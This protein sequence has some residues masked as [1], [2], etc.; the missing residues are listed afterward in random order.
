MKYVDNGIDQK[1]ER[2]SLVTKFF[3]VKQP[4]EPYT[5]V[6]KDM[7]IED[8]TEIDGEEDIKFPLRFQFT[9]KVSLFIDAPSGKLTI[10]FD[11]SEIDFLRKHTSLAKVNNLKIHIADPGTIINYE[12]EYVFLDR[13]LE[14][15][16]NQK[17]I[18]THQWTN[19]LLIESY[20]FDKLLGRTLVQLSDL[21]FVN[22]REPVQKMIVINGVRVTLNLLYQPFKLGQVKEGEEEE[23]EEEEGSVV[24]E[25]SGDQSKKAAANERSKIQFLKNKIKQME[26]DNLVARTKINKTNVIIY[27][28]FN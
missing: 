7:N 19:K 23:E 18:Q 15:E 12:P 1:V 9:Y 25:K 27:N 2:E 14:D 16:S 11:Q 10:K 20:D 13:S 3:S 8:P 5:C 4:K 22:K 6:K 26:N 28:I 21:P 24:A 17:T